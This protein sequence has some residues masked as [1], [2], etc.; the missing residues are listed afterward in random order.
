M[1]VAVTRWPQNGIGVERGPLVYSLPIGEKW[2]TKV[3]PK[4][5]TPEFPSWEAMPATDW[6]Y[7]LALDAANLE[8]EVDVKMRPVASD[9]VLDPWENPPVTIAVP[10]RKIEDWELQ[11]NPDDTAQKFTP[12]LPDL[13]IS[14]INETLEKVSLVPYGSTQL[15]VTIFPALPPEGTS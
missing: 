11:A 6:N 1:K 10:A 9:Q 2:T 14:K 12:C 7:G 15:R 5:T 3:E 4:Y 13:S 8:R